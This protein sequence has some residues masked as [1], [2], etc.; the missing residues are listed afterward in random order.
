MMRM[1]RRQ[2]ALAAAGLLA[3]GAGAWIAQIG[4]YQSG[5]Q[6]DEPKVVTPGDGAKPPSDALV[7]FDGKNL[8]E[9]EGGPWELAGEAMIARKSSI[10]TKKK[11]GDCQLHV[12]FATPAKVEGSGQGRGNSGVLFFGRY[13]VQ[14]LDSYINKTYFDGQ[15]A[16]IYKQHPP[17]VNACRGPGEWQTYDIAF[18]AP[19]FDG[20]KLTSPAAV[21]VFHNGVLV[22]NHFV[23]EGNTD[24]N[25]LPKYYPHEAAG[26]LE[27]QFHNNT[28]RYRNLWIREIAEVPSKRVH[29]PL[30]K[31]FR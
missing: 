23:L 8:D 27:L 21:T 25:R 26:Q 7:L 10:R 31:P 29:E 9:W 4:E 14:V 2:A 30:L 13:E 16:S 20:E 22:Q 5:I 11:F 1:G 18:T 6:W 24:Y 28:T 15:A 17:L 12:E 19:R 3:G